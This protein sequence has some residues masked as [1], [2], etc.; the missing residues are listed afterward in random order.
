MRNRS[1]TSAGAAAVL[2]AAL[3]ACTP[4]SPPPPDAPKGAWA[5]EQLAPAP[6]APEVQAAVDAPPATGHAKIIGLA[7]LPNARIVL[8]VRAG[9]CEALLL[10]TTAPADATAPT[11]LGAP[12]PTGEISLPAD[13][14]EFPAKIIDSPYSR[15]SGIATPYFDYLSLGCSENAM[16]VRVE[17]I[18]TTTAASTVGD[19]VQTWRDGQY[20]YVTAGR[21]TRPSP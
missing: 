3:A 14:K 12:R 1:K 15:A 18:Q 8:A 9:R 21:A 7:G 2:A 5:L 13:R 10:P 11:G 20:L 6:V 19:S 17:G 4:A 16:G